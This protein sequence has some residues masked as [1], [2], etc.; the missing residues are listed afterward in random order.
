VTRAKPIT[1]F[2]VLLTLLQ[3]IGISARSFWA[4]EAYVGLIVTEPWRPFLGKLDTDVHHPLYII[5]AKAWFSVAGNSEFALRSLS[6]LALLA[7]FLVFFRLVS[8]MNDEATACW[9]SLFFVFS[10]AVLLY[11]RMAR[12][13]SLSLLFFLLALWLVHEWG[14]RPSKWRG[15]L[16]FLMMT[17]SWFLTEPLGVLG[18]THFLVVPRGSPVRRR[19]LVTWLLSLIPYAVWLWVWRGLLASQMGAGPSP[20]SIAFLRESSLKLGLALYQAI[21]GETVPALWVIS[22]AVVLSAAFA[23]SGLRR[24][25]PPALLLSLLWLPAMSALATYPIRVGTDF[26]PARVFF[27][28]PGMYWLLGRGLTRFRPST[29]APLALLLLAPMAVGLGFTYA[30]SN[31]LTSTYVTPWREVTRAILRQADPNDWAIADEVPLLYYL[32]RSWGAGPH[33]A[34]VTKDTDIDRLM[35]EI[36]ESFP[37]RI[38]VVLNPRDITDGKITTVAEWV[39]VGYDLVSQV[40]LVVEAPAVTR[41]KS[42]F[43]ITLSPVKRELRVYQ[44]IRIASDP[45]A[46]DRLKNLPEIPLIPESLTGLSSADESG[47]DVGDADQ[48]DPDR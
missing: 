27:L 47:A 23:L 31:S 41:L 25:V 13:Y 14:R 43:A 38:F 9:S 29:R 12:Y 1:V 28:L 7:G 46:E 22:V 42:R 32:R 19:V 16:Y 5:A 20:V 30:Q 6:V 33:T 4:D 45:F 36:S 39:S 37:S 44:S 21:L 17:G 35:D 18:A 15:I 10:P 40:P 24:P 8:A 3:V 26:L 2:L 34:I 48:T 11:G